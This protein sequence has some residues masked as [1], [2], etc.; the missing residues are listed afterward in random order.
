MSHWLSQTEIRGEERAAYVT[1]KDFKIV[2]GMGFDHVRI[3]IDEVQ[4]WTED[5]APEQEAFKLL[6]NGIKWSLENGLRVIVDLHTLRS[7]HFNRADSRKLWEDKTAQEQF[8]GF[9]QQLSS[10]LKA[11]SVDS[12]AYEIMNEAVAE[13]PEDWNNLM[14]WAIGELRKLEPDRIIVLGSNRWQIPSTFKDLRVPEVDRN[15]ILSFHFYT[16]FCL[17]HYK[18]H[19]NPYYKYEGPVSYPGWSV[20]TTLYANMNPEVLTEVKKHN[21][22]Y[23][24]DVLEKDILQAVTVAKQFNLPLYC[25]EFGCYPTTPI[26]SR[27]AWYRDMIA[28]FDKHDIAFAHWNYK[29]D[30]PVVNSDLSPISEIVD[31]MVPK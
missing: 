4:F 9:W 15:I 30:F 2:A 8:I 29:N 14:Q 26:K 31:I 10:E 25:G 1:E 28:I 7:H 5:G 16:P 17:T 13:D 11:Y 27:Q 3:P 20:D 24:R 18:A 19:W 22:Y 12:V 6:H 21:G 23:D